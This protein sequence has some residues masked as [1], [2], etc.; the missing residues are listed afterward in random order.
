MTAKSRVGA[1]SPQLVPPD[2]LERLNLGLDQTV[3]LSETLAMDSEV[4]WANVF[5][6]I[7]VPPGFNAAKVNPKLALAGAALAASPRLDALVDHLSDMVRGWAC[8]GM[9]HRAVDLPAAIADLEPLANDHHFGV[10]EWAWLALRPLVVAEPIRAVG[11]LTE[12]SFRPE[13]N[14]RRF[15]SEATR[16]RG[17]WCAHISELKAEPWLGLPLLEPMKSDPSRYVQNSVAN[18][19]NDAAK[20]QPEWVRSVC[21]RWSEECPAR[22]TAYIVKRAMRSLGD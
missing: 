1:T 2:V 8:A 12:W 5:P 18:W 19:L 4:L 7:P 17:V 14:L 16:P 6:E 22:E 10:R 13:E 3:N 11:I 20:S 15:A 21:A 9:V